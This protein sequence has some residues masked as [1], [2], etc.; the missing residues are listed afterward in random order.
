[1]KKLALLMCLG[2]TQVAHAQGERGLYMGAELGT[3]DYEESGPGAVLSDDTYA[4]ELLGGYRVNEHFGVEVGLGRTGDLEGEFTEDIPG[5][6]P[7]TFEVDG[8]YDIYA[9][10]AVGLLPFEEF[11]L[12][13]AAGYYSA[14]L[15]GPV[16]VAGIGE[17]FQADG[18]QRGATAA[19]GI[20]RDFGL[21]LRS[22]S[23]RGQYKWYDFEDGI[24]AAGFSVGVLF[25]F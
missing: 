6:G 13:G 18:H 1:M 20:Q 21:D 16:S 11:T 14:S 10:R 7:I 22:F 5:L 25:R 23:I 12:F 8:V 2:I 4:Y 9:V 3:F 15:G 17:V 19:F 24:D